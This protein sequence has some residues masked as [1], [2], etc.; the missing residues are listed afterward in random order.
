MLGRA[1]VGK[2][3]WAV[4]RSGPELPLLVLDLIDH[5]FVRVVIDASDSEAIATSIGS[6]S[7][8]ER[9]I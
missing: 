2:Q 8:P 3:F 4:A 5:E 1:V 6:D 9:D 7:S